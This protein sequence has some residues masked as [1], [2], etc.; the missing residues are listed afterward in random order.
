MST[1]VEQIENEIARFEAGTVKTNTGTIVTIA[2]GVAK[3][4]RASPES[5]TMK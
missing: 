3:L 2:D 5:C 1:I 4:Q